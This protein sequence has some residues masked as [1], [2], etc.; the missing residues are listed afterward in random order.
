MKKLLKSAS[1]FI[2]YHPWLWWMLNFTWGICMTLLGLIATL[3]MLPF[4][5]PKRY[6]NCWFV[7]A[8]K[9]WGGLD[10]GCMF[11]ICKEWNEQTRQH[12]YG[13]TFQNAILG[14]FFIFIIAIPSATRYWI[15]HFQR[16]HGKSL[17][18]YDAIWFESSATEIGALAT[19]AKEE[20]K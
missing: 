3:L 19:K 7:E 6:C 12:E 17:K 5:K 20:R 11:I 16:K 13:H 10:L 14:P 18:A 9:R 8:G 15:R 4:S 2:I 1:S